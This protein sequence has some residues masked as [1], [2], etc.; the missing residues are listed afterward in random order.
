[1]SFFSDM[2]GGLGNIIGE[3]VG[4]VVDP[5]DAG[6]GDVFRDLGDTAQKFSEQY[7]DTIMAASALAAGGGALLGGTGAAGAS[8]GMG[9]GVNVGSIA[10]PAAGGM[11]SGAMAGLGSLAAPT[12]GATAATG[13]MGAM[14][15]NAAGSVAGVESAG[16]LDSLGSFMNVENF[17]TGM[18][19]MQAADSMTSPQVQPMQLRSNARGAAAYMTPE[20]PRVEKTYGGLI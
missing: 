1:M 12:G 15:Y 18:G 14:G 5:F 8:T 7:G 3:T 4:T 11:G 19:L 20:A 17:N 13:G 16:L 10:S 9:A 6:Y 2:I